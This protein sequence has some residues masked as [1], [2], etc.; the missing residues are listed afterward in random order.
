M[1][2][3][4]AMKFIKAVPMT[5][6]TL[7]ILN[8]VHVYDGRIQVGNTNIIVDVPHSSFK[9]LDFTAP[10]ELVTKAVAA[11][12]HEFTKVELEAGKL[13]LAKGTFKVTIPLLTHEDYPRLDHERGASAPCVP[14]FVE[15]LKQLR[16]FAGNA[17]VAPYH[18]QN[19]IC[20]RDGWAYATNNVTVARVPIT[21]AG[22]REITVNLDIIDTLAAI[23]DR[24]E[25]V[26]IEENFIVF[27][28]HCGGWV[29]CRVIENAWPTAV[30]DMLGPAKEPVPAGLPEVVAGMAAFSQKD[31]FFG[32]PEGVRTDGGDC[33]AKDGSFALPVACSYKL[34]ELKAALAAAEAFD[35]SGYP[36]SRWSGPGIEGFTAGR[37][38]GDA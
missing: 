27:K 36:N 25:H 9:G 18:W 23:G 10:I 20:F 26:A 34:S 28:Y 24:P 16:P 31:A 30:D 15:R 8:S 7:P 22:N 21:A 12:D 19:G 33:G 35:F 32:G 3:K 6:A 5:A 38:L 37:R 17:M 4:Q 13:I 11:C 1:H 29:R 2:L 14:E